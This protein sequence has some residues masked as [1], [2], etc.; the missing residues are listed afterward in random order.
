MAQGNSCVGERLVNARTLVRQCIAE[1]GVRIR[2]TSNGPSAIEA[3]EIGLGNFNST[4]VTFE[5]CALM[6]PSDSS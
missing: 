5:P 4:C 6:C 2:S 1:S 3:I